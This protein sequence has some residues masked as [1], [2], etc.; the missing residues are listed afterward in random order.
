M[1]VMLLAGIQPEMRWAGPSA[2][3]HVLAA[4]VGGKTRGPVVRQP[5]VDY[6]TGHQSARR[7]GHVDLVKPSG[8]LHRIKIRTDSVSHPNSQVTSQPETTSPP[9]PRL[10]DLIAAGFEADPKASAYGSQ[11]ATG[12]EASVRGSRPALNATESS[13]RRPM[14]SSETRVAVRLAGGVQVIDGSPEPPVELQPLTVPV[15]EPVTADGA[16]LRQEND[17]VTL[18]ASDADLRS[19]L[20]MIADHHRLNLVVGPDVDGPVTVSLRGARLEEVLD[21]IVGIA[22]FHWHQRDNVL[23]VTA[24]TSTELDPK[25]QGRRLQ[26]YPLN[27]V[28]AKDV[29]P[30]VTGLL[31]PIGKSFVTQASDTEKLQTRELLVVE[32]NETGHARIS[33]Y[34][35]QVDIAPPQVLVEAHV[36]Q[37]DLD[38][39]QRHGVDLTGLA[40]VAGARLT[41]NGN[42][43]AEEEAEGPSLAFRIDGNDVDGLIEV[44]H[45]NTASRTLASPKVSVV[46][47]QTAKVQIGQR[48]PYAV[49][50][51]TQ[52]AT[53]QNVQFLDVGIVLEVTP[54]I[55]N[56]RNVLMTVL[57]KIS[58]GR[59]TESGFP[60]EDTTQVSTTVLMPDGSGLVI[61]GLIREVDESSDAVVPGL[62]RV[63]VVKRLF[64]KQ[65]RQSSRNELVVALVTH[66][67]DGPTP[68][69]QRECVDL[70]EALPG[71]A[72]RALSL[73]YGR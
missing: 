60:E 13:S 57:P 53:I 71:Y 2:I 9:E 59:I 51:T 69:R 39:E 20:R 66:I 63:P 3:G 24:S 48:L 26:V 70:S 62:S 17:L 55:T 58:G 36:L 72:E 64:T 14:R 27:Y 40:R 30:V 10:A 52:T 8:R 42:G 5:A 50:T 7:Q 31:S 73:P 37:I 29:E 15:R 4:P 35:A 34:L 38:D 45:A 61:G 44:I 41:L 68:I 46:N 32:D 6:Q 28:A 22:G 21:A 49:A 12:A 65:F 67:L 56:D 11:D 1:S 25:V 33:Q 43:F 54:V 19:V 16:T 18:V 47:R 23:Y